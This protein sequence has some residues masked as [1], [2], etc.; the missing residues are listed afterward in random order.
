VQEE[1]THTDAFAMRRQK[2][3][4]SS[5]QQTRCPPENFR[6][7]ARGEGFGKLECV[8]PFGCASGFER[9]WNT[10]QARQERHDWPANRTKHLKGDAHRCS[11]ELR[12]QHCERKAA[13][14]ERPQAECPTS[15]A[16][17]LRGRQAL[18]SSTWLWWSIF[19]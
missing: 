18:G 15:K 6:W 12:K 7:C 19:P 13:A 8:E 11:M 4:R 2:D 14:Q 9:V 10:D 17:R 16:S 3:Q 1:G 5:G